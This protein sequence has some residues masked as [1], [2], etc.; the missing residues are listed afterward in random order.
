MGVGGQCE[1]S[2]RWQS[3]KSKPHILTVLSAE[4]ETRMV[5]SYEMSRHITGSCQG[6]KGMAT[7]GC[8]RHG[9]MQHGD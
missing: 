9:R 8:Q 6:R 5:L 1:G 4:P 7:A 2:H 3:P